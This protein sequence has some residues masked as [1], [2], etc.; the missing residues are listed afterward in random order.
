[1]KRVEKDGTLVPVQ[2][3]RGNQIVIDVSDSS[4]SKRS[5]SVSCQDSEES[6]ELDISEAQTEIMSR[7][8]MMENVVNVLLAK[9]NDL[10]MTL[11]QEREEKKQLKEEVSAYR[12]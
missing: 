9:I 2:N 10:E 6:D 4:N 5:I 1:M 8:E 3:A 11:A 7:V 12:E